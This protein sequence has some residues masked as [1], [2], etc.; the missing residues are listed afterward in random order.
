[1]AQVLKDLSY[2]LGIQVDTDLRI[3]HRP[4]NDAAGL[5]FLRGRNLTGYHLSF[6][7]LECSC[8]A[9]LALFASKQVSHTPTFGSY[10][11]MQGRSVWHMDV[12]DP[13]FCVGWAIW[14]VACS[15]QNLA[16]G[17]LALGSLDSLDLVSVRSCWYVRTD[18]QQVLLY[19]SVGT[20]EV[21]G[22]ILPLWNV[23]RW[24]K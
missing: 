24:A 20:V 11:L 15:R 16:G 6:D 1:M 17:W 12:D 22:H 14:Q 19:V 13:L 18:G 3:L 21:P 9:S 10:S 8:H 7:C 23:N 4:S 5:V 2:V